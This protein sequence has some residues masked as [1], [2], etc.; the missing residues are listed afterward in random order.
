MQ[1]FHFDRA[2]A[3]MDSAELIY[4]DAQVQTALQQMADKLNQRFTQ[5]ETPQFPLVLGVM[6]GAVVFTG[7]LLTKLTFPL[8]FDY[9]HVTRYGEQDVGGK[10]VWK[11]V[12]R[13][14]VAGRS[15]IVL[16]D[17][18]D[19]GATLAEV[20]RHLLEL[21]AAEVLVGV[22]ADKA[23]GRSKPIAADYVGLTVPNKFIV[24]FGMDAFGYW[25][26]LPGI[27][28]VQPDAIK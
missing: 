28:A 6:G 12:P 10:V 7:Q 20:K 13:S 3:L 19:E 22:F 9:I 15:V 26:N 5:T 8:E 24:G 11:V 1:E 27:W 21:G 16:D 4:D 23:I 25:R 17:I 18:L 2:Q 14:N